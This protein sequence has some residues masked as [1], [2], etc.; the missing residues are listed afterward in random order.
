MEQEVESAREQEEQP[1]SDPNEIQ[2][3]E[4]ELTNTLL[5]VQESVIVPVEEQSDLVLPVEEPSHAMLPEE[6]SPVETFQGP[7]REER[8]FLG[9]PSSRSSQ[10]IVEPLEE[11]DYGDSD[12][13]EA[14]ITPEE[15]EMQRRAVWDENQKILKD[16]AKQLDA[17]RYAREDLERQERLLEQET[18]ALL[19]AGRNPP[20]KAQQQLAQKVVPVQPTRSELP[21]GPYQCL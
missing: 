1:P 20:K 14:L 19:R 18:A 9:R 21:E 5:P 17:L 6:D 7:E 2:V 16:K 15:E 4:E 13:E 10:P 12:L 8:S 11:V 3:P